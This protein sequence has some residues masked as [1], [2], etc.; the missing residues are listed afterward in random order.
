M[1]E[2]RIRVFIADDHGFIVDVLKSKF[3]QG[4]DFEFAGRASSIDELFA[5]LNGRENVV[6]LDMI[7]EPAEMLAAIEKLQR[8]FPAVKIVV[9]TG[10]ED[11][12]S[13]NRH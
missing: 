5:R 1:G 7:G 8:S 6:L 11:C 9:R 12:L 3:S 4:E 10:K 2:Q 13:P